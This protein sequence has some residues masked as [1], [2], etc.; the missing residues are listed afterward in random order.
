MEKKEAMKI[1]KEFHDNSALFSVRTA[2]DTVIPELAESEDEKIRKALIEL[3]KYEGGSLKFLDSP[4]DDVPMDTMLAWLEK[5]GKET[6]WKPSREEMYVLYVLS[7]ITDEFDEQKEEVITRLY[8]DLK[9]EFFNGA[10][11]E[12]MFPANTS[13]ELEKQRET[14]TQKDVDNAYLKGI[15]DAKNELEKQREQKP[16][17]KV[18]PKFKVGDWVV[19]NRNDS[20]REIMQIYDIRDD[21]YYFNDNVHFSWSIKECDE[22]CHLWTIQ[23]ASD[24]DVFYECNEKILSSLK[25]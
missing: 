19:Y 25:S 6:S 14:F 10:S 8:Q 1:L 3:V 17:D 7:C 16:A 12:N 24:G 9:R 11:F 21:R 22:K 4:F 23:D 20:S 2:L 15:S 13:T 5:Q 18:E